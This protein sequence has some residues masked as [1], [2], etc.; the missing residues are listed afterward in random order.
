M[1]NEI[2]VT[3]EAPEIDM[4]AA[5]NDIAEGLN[6]NSPEES[7]EGI[8]DE[9]H[10]DK[11]L[12]NEALSVEGEAGPASGETPAVEDTGPAAPKTWRPDAAAKWAALP[13]EVRAEVAKREEDMFRGLETYKVDANFGKSVQSALAPYLPT[14]RQHNIDPVAQIS[15]LMRAHYT[16]ATG[17]PEQKQAYFA[18][19]AKDY[20]ILLPGEEAPYIDPAVAELQTQLRTLQS[21]L[22]SREQEEQTTRTTKLRGE[23][24]SFATDPAH[25]YFDEV[26]NDIA[27]LIKSGT[28]KDLADAYDKA[29]WANPTTR[30]KEQARMTTE[31]AA[32]AKKEAGEK[33]AAAKRAA[34]ANVRS[35]SKPA[36]GTTPLGS[37]D[38][39]LS[40]ALAGIKARA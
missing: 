39:T 25:P 35:S 27:G 22:Q 12:G 26:A 14:L 36:G 10:D 32:K 29:V 8:P 13:P 9:S 15:G 20:G 31:A 28:A 1:E 23:I 6:F 34:S 16:L 7:N 21:Q 2:E 37:I 40:A 5:M 30:A 11:A 19:L 24:D 18:S 17:S 4:D 3:N 38:D 33:A